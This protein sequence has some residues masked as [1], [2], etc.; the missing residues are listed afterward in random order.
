MPLA[1]PVSRVRPSTAGSS[2]PPRPRPRAL[3]GARTLRPSRTIDFDLRELPPAP[4]SAPPACLDDEDWT[5]GPGPASFSGASSIGRQ[6]LS[7]R[8]SE[9]PI[10]FGRGT[11]AALGMRH[12]G[13][14]GPGTYDRTGALG[15]QRE[16]QF[17]TGKSYSM[18]SRVKFGAFVDTKSAAKGPAPGRYEVRAG[19]TQVVNLKE[20]TPAAFSFS[21]A[22][23]DGSGKGSGRG[24]PAAPGPGAYRNRH[25][26]IGR[27]TLSQRKNIAV[28]GF[29]RRR[30][31]DRPKSAGEGVGA[32]HF[33]NV[34]SLGRQ[35]SSRWKT[36][37]SHGFAADGRFR[38]GSQ[39]E[40][41]RVPGPG[42]Y[43]HSRGQALGKQVRSQ[44][45]SAPVAHLS[46]RTAFGNPFGKFGRR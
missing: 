7:N 46:G 45:K 21:Y 11:D 34:E 36:S 19:V 23:R 15:A 24:Q 32:E 22:K 28:H 18:R 44:F 40:L 20:R 39:R 33:A 38:D 41:R 3:G 4:T 30:R 5:P 12:A 16:S 1:S 14:P 6:H 17:K 43:S 13:A 27:Q 25:H 9:S 42:K 26:A 29:R 10:V 35:V 37:Q 2:R 31:F 8:R